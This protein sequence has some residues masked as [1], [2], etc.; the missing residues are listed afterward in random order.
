MTGLPRVLVIAALTV[1]VFDTIGSL[2]SNATGFP[3]GLLAPV[4]FLIYAA[5]GFFAFRHGGFRTAAVGGGMTAL[6]DATLGW[7][8]SWVIGPGRPPEGLGMGFLLFTA[9]SVVVM[10]VLLGLAGGLVARLTGKRP[11]ADSEQA[12]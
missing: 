12:G 2:A 8:I 5:A 9:A 10:A 1:V 11:R 7:A 6:V 3:Y 4:S